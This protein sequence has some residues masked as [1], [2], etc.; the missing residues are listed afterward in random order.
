LLPQ[1]RVAVLAYDRATDFTTNHDQISQLIERLRRSNERIEA[2]L[3]QRFSGLAAVYG[4]RGMPPALQTE[5]A[6]FEGAECASLY[7]DDGPRGISLKENSSLAFTTPAVPEAARRTPDFPLRLVFGWNPAAW[8]TGAL[9]QR[10][11][12]LRREF[13]ESTLSL[14]PGDLKGAGIKAGWPAKVVTPGGE[15]VLTAREDARLPEHLDTLFVAVQLVGLNRGQPVREHP[16][17]VEGVHLAPQRACRPI[18]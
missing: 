9:S 3:A 12:I 2:L 11:E 13:P 5:I 1:D 6:P 17:R 18:L 10:E 8:S 7:A 16:L 4:S 14:S 15:A